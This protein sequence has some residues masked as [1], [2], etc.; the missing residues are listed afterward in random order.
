MGKQRKEGRKGD[1]LEINTRPKPMKTYDPER[2]RYYSDCFEKR[3]RPAGYA[4]SSNNGKFM[5]R[6]CFASS[7]PILESSS[8]LVSL[9][10][11]SIHCPIHLGWD[12]RE[13]AADIQSGR[14]SCL[15]SDPNLI[16][17]SGEGYESASVGK[18][19]NFPETLF[20]SLRVSSSQ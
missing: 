15:L 19:R 1:R 17:T 6:L 3:R 12:M 20:L 4:S 2:M 10:S 8:P 11:H 9:F 14:S 18:I 13:V 16:R 7:S 5:F